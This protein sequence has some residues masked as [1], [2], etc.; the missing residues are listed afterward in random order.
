MIL[1]D[2]APLRISLSHECALSLPIQQIY[3]LFRS[4]DRSR[5]IKGCCGFSAARASDA[6]AALVKYTDQSSVFVPV[7]KLTRA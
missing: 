2:R 1:R 5:R 7:V 4:G 3:P 6:A